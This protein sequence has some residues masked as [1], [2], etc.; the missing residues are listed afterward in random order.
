MTGSETTEAVWYM[1]VGVLLIA[2]ALARSVIA[3]LPMTGAMIY[4][5]VGFVIGPAGFGLLDVSIHENTRVLRV[6]TE[7]GLIVSLFA[8]GLHLR[9]PLENNLWS[10][11]FRL[12]LPAMFITIAIMAVAAHVGLGFSV[13][14]ALLLGAALAPTDPVLASELRPREAGDDDPL[15]FSL[16]GEGGANDGAAYPFAL[17]GVLL[18]LRDTQA[19]SHPL[20]L[21]AQLVWG[22]VAA[23]GIGWGMG[24]LTET[25]VAKLRIR[26]AKAMGFEGFLAL[27]LMAAC[28]GVTIL[29]HGYGFLAVFCAGVALRRREMRA[30]GE[31][32]PR[33]ALRDVSHGE[34]RAAAKDPNLAHAYLAESMMAFS[35]EMERI[36]ELALM[37]LIGAVI[38][39]HWRDLLGWAPLA[40]MLL[41]FFVAR[42]L[43]VYAAMAGTGTRWRQRLVSAWLG[44]R[45]VGTFYYLLFALERAPE[46]ARALMPIALGVLVASVFVHG[47][48]ASPVLN[49]YYA[50]R[51][52][53]P[54]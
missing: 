36:V 48:S 28:Y 19:L 21:T 9:A 16:S 39:A 49:W 20:L 3:R 54:E 44:F 22:V 30:T 18:C 43:A 15:R 37:L 5:V 11:P 25:L 17:L 51:P 1:L 52:P 12:A 34:R 7:T 14:A 45:G 50:R 27:G 23:V 42:P 13:G 35:V 2:V 33:E 29:V 6:I 31:E 47:V 8:I 38:S 53:A 26:Y 10:P 46:Q 4:L 32:K 24:T 40:M 41:L